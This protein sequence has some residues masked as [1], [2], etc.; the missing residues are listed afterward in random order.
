MSQERLTGTLVRQK[1]LFC[2]GTARNWRWCMDFYEQ[3]GI[4]KLR[5]INML[6]CELTVITSSDSCPN[7]RDGKSS[8]LIRIVSM[9][10]RITRVLATDL[11][12]LFITVD[13]NVSRVCPQGAIILVGICKD[14]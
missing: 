4:I 2:V 14:I 1:S 11:I 6:Q 12:D 10:L 13:P 5:S 8:F 3:M 7:R 9:C